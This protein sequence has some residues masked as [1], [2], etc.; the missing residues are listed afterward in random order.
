VAGHHIDSDLDSE[1]RERERKNK[2]HLFKQN[3]ALV[4]ESSSDHSVDIYKR[5][6]KESLNEYYQNFKHQ[7]TAGQLKF[8]SNESSNTNVSLKEDE[9]RRRIRDNEEFQRQEK[10]R[11]LN[12]G[13]DKIIFC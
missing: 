13:L 3:T 8:S 11:D 7:R 12:I 5:E 6:S 2:K 1:E 9:I 10:M 4:S